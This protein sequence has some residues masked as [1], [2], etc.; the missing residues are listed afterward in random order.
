[1]NELYEME[2]AKPIKGSEV[3]LTLGFPKTYISERGEVFAYLG[4]AGKDH[5]A[6]AIRC[7]SYEY[8]GKHS[9][10]NIVAKNIYGFYRLVRGG[11][12]L[13]SF[14]DKG[15]RASVTYKELNSY[16][17]LPISGSTYYGAIDR[18]T[19]HEDEAVTRA[20]FGL[21]HAELSRL[22]EGYGLLF[23]LSN[24]Y[25]RL[26]RVMRSTQSDNICDLSGDWI[27]KGFPYI[28][29]DNSGYPF[30]HISLRAFYSHIGLLMKGERK[31]PIWM[32]L[33]K[34]GT[35]EEI[36]SRVTSL[37]GG[38]VGDFSKVVR[39]GEFNDW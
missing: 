36:L 13:D 17:D 19:R 20:I 14:M 39:Y 29:F 5:P 28:A 7:C 12:Y 3:V 25:I 34:C 31:N 9:T 11:I 15:Y 23:G 10:D 30:S 1:M 32:G 6:M 38:S 22:L 2:S 26:P 24:D 18:K 27:P 21:T 35:D 8:E 16:L 4:V 37:N 33:A